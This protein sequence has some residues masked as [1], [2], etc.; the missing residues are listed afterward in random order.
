VANDFEDID[1]PNIPIFPLFPNWTTTPNSEIA[2]ARTLLQYRGSAQRLIP[3]TDDVPISFEAKFTTYIKEDEYSLLD[4]WNERKGK[5]E[6]FWSYHPKIAFELKR[7]IGSGA[8]ALVC[9]HNYA[10]SQYQGYE[11]IYIIMNDGDILTRH[12]TNVSYDDLLDELTVEI[13]TALD[14]DVNLDNHARIG[15]LLLSRFDE[16]EMSLTHR[17]DLATETDFRFYELVKEYDEV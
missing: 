12:V 11:R 10:E 9:L 2:L 15:R 7:D 4:F 13:S 5:N 16:D 3:F 8:T 17:S 14:R 6:R 1:Y